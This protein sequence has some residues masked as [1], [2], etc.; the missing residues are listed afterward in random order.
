M[1]GAPAEADLK[2]LFQKYGFTP[3][4]AELWSEFIEQVLGVLRGAADELRRPANWHAFKQKRGALGIV[5]VRKRRQVTERIPIE[6]AITSELAHYIRHMR[7]SLPAGHFLRL[8]EVEF[9]VEDMVQSDTRAG[10]HSRKVDFFIYAASGLDEPE[11]AIEAKPLVAEA[12]INARYLAEEGIGCFLTTDSPYTRRALGG[13]LA[14]TIS[15]IGRSWRTEVRAA[16]RAYTPKVIELA[17]V[18]IT[19]QSEPL[20]CSRHNRDAL[21]LEPIAILHL[22]MIFQPDVDVEEEKVL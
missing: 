8:N 19:G 22:E 1:R 13:M 20:I 21:R 3:V 6:D 16:V 10:R 18:G 5:R 9:H 14:Y 11:F 7:R 12:D 17:D 2:E 15:G 4:K